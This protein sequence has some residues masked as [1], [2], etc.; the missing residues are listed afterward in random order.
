MHFIPILQSPQRAPPCCPTQRTCM[1]KAATVE[2]LARSSAATKLL[3]GSSPSRA[4]RVGGALKCSILAMLV[5]HWRLTAG[6]TLD[7]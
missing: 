7:A 3:T 5:R 2:S 6:V 1:P 4:S